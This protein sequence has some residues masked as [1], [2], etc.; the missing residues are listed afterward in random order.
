MESKY[1]LAD[2]VVEK[3]SKEL[4]FGDFGDISYI[5]FFGRQVGETAA[6]QK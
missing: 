4:H 1:L 6:S 3:Q 5:L 2:A